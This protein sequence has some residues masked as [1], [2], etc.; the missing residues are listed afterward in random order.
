MTAWSAF[1][2]WSVSATLILGTDARAAS[3][4]AE[5]GLAVD[6]DSTLDVFEDTHP[7]AV[8]AS[9]PLAKSMNL[10]VCIPFL[11]CTILTLAENLVSMNMAV[12]GANKSGP[13]S[14]GCSESS[15]VLDV[16]HCQSHCAVSR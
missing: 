1:E 7:A 8:S 11:S 15:T 14:L 6:G 12:V 2:R 10:S 3:L 13:V 9:S 16:K 5:V 4:S